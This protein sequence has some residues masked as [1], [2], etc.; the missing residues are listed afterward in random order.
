MKNKLQ[1]KKEDYEYIPL[2]DDSN[3]ACFSDLGCV[4]GLIEK[5]FKLVSLDK[6]NPYK[7]IF[8]FAKESGISKTADD[9]WSGNLQVDARSYFDTIKMLKNRLYS[10]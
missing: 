5:S 3:Y 10:E 6:E 8:I 9:Y 1:N 4:G 7:V 2:N